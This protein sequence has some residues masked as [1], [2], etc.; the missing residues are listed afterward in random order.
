[1]RTAVV[2]DTAKV[3]FFKQITTACYVS[4]LSSCCLRYCKSTIF[5]ANHNSNDTQPL[6]RQL[7][8]ILQKYDFSS[9]SQQ[10]ALRKMEDESCLRYCKSTI[11]Q[12]NHNTISFSPCSI[13]L[14]A[15]LQKYDFSSK[16]Q[17]IK[18]S[19][20]SV[21]SCLRYCKSTIFQ[22]NHNSDESAVRERV[23][24]CDTA[25]VRFFKQITTPRWEKIYDDKLFA[26]LQKYDFSSKSQ[27]NTL[28]RRRNMCC[29][30]YCK[31]TIF[32]ANH[33]ARDLDLLEAFVVCDTA[34]VRF[35]KQI[36]TRKPSK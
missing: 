33:N 34:K 36:T 19:P 21:I 3:R 18:I 12:A 2:C 24:V 32:Q 27:P 26:I 20:K 14:F 22:A 15:I 30:R 11:F 9:K 10:E 4:C 6:C 23:V 28:S 31:S 16:S 29:L 13:L 7:F 35:F 25:K 8:A 5:Q 1:M 17:L